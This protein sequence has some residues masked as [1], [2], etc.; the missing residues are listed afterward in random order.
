M[1]RHKIRKRSHGTKGFPTQ[2]DDEGLEGTSIQSK[3][4]MF[5]RMHGGQSGM[6]E[7]GQDG[8]ASDYPAGPSRKGGKG[9]KSSGS[10]GIASRGRRP[11]H[12]APPVKQRD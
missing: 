3:A 8:E 5:G 9:P 12:N 6:T 11:T 7:P 10:V 1:A 2:A 4:P